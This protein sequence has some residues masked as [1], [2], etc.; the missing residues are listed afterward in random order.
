MAACLGGRVA[1]QL[2]LG[3]ISTGASNDLERA[4]SIARAM[5]TKYGMSEKLGH[6]TFTT[7]SDE[8]FIG[9]SMAQAKPY[10]EQTAAL[11]DQEVKDLLD[12][13]YA[14]C[15][16]ILERDRDKLELV[17]QF[18]LEHETMDAKQFQLV[19]DDPAALGTAGETRES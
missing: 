10:S 12:R 2:M 14:R 15:R 18:L 11:I 7:G 5:V 17:A 4:T 13:A 19:Y 8:V 9:R 3:D 16:E 1:E 6:A